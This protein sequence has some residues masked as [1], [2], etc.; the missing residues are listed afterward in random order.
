M[1]TKH[2]KTHEKNTIERYEADDTR[3]FESF[4]RVDE[5]REKSVD[6]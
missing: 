4:W 5:V 2:T 1:Y 6:F 3:E